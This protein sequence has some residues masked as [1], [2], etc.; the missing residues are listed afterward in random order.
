[1]KI[2]KIFAVITGVALVG[3]SLLHASDQTIHYGGRESVKKA[4]VAV[5]RTKCK[6]LIKQ[7]KLQTKQPKAPGEI[8]RVDGDNR[9]AELKDGL[10][11]PLKGIMD[12]IFNFKN[13]NPKSDTQIQP[14]FEIGAIDLQNKNIVKNDNTPLSRH[15][16]RILEKCKAS[17]PDLFENQ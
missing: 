5:S 15:N 12:K 13:S 11:V 16:E 10:K 4:D 17:Y 14:E 3:P 2:F 7:E 1:M 8:P 9:S 6:H